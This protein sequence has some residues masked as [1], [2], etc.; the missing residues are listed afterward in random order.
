MLNE[1]ISEAIAK[2]RKKLDPL[3]FDKEI[4]VLIG[5]SKY[6]ELVS[7][8][9][10]HVRVYSLR[11]D[12]HRPCFTFEGCDI[13]FSHDDNEVKVQIRDRYTGLTKKSIKIK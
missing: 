2:C 10:N 12:G 13:K 1:K 6:C 3:S 11:P 8:W 5:R 7:E 4:I 9:D